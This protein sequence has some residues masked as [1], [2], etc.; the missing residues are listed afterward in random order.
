MVRLGLIVAA[1]AALAGGAAAAPLE[2]YG[3]LPSIEDASISADGSQVA[4]VVTNGEERRIVVKDLV[5]NTIPLLATVGQTKV[6]D[7]RW[8]GDKH[9]ILTTS[10]TSTPMDVIAGKGEWFFASLI[11]VPAKKLHPLLTDAEN[12]M[13]VLAGTPIV[14]MVDGR[15][16]VLLQGVHFVNSQGV[17][18]LFQID[19]GRGASHMLDVGQNDTEDFLVGPDGKTVGQVLYDRADGRWTL[20]A[21]QGVAWREILARQEPI[22]PPTVMGM[23][24]SPRTLLIAGGEKDDFDW[25]E[26]SLD[27]GKSEPIPS[28]VDDQGPIHDPA[29]GRLI[30]LRVLAG[31]ARRYT[32]FDPEDQR[33]WNAVVA[34][35]PGDQVTLSSW[36]NDRRRILVRVDSATVGPAYAVVDLTS[37]SASWLGSEYEGLKA[38]DIA[39]VKALHFKA[40]DGLELTGYLTLP[41]GRDPKGLPLIVFPHG[42]PASRDTLGFDWWAQAMASRGYAVLQVNFRGSEGFGWDFTKAGFGEWGRKMQ[43]DLSDGVAELAKQG[44]ID[45]RRVCIVGGSYGG[46]AALAGATLQ[47]GVYRCAASF[48]GVADLRRMVSYSRGR[49]GKAV[50]RY[51]T[52][53]MG[54]EDMGDPVLAKYS[55]AQHAAE[56]S[57]PIL[58]I[59]G[60]DDTVVPLEQSRV[61]ADALR[62][63]GK[64]VELVVQNNADHWLSLGDTRLQMLQSTMAFV[65]KHNPPR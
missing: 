10:N 23:G 14:R 33:V 9:L 25:Q 55:P 5:K 39:Q 18:T 46:Y 15:P 63:A 59:H 2:A 31:D 30:G 29:T 36:S 57:A 4:V 51:W 52:R 35:F 44:V 34:A 28:S 43:T 26:I 62:S 12:A 19:L 60:K 24:R 65:E 7:L 45:P 47:K 17:T 16:V 50:Q 27:T 32:F 38:A 37:R 61:M 54:A 3:R 6:R 8:A 20:K 64:P 49:G 42:G 53:Y 1:C 48:G 41:N 58:L 56:A 22:D 40:A 21:K 13:N 11:D